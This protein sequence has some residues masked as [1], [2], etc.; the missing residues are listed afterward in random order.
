MGYA[1]LDNYSDGKH[2][3]IDAES[4]VVWTVRKLD[5]ETQKLFNF[6]VRSA[7]FGQPQRHNDVMVTVMIDDVNDN[8]P[9]FEKVRKNDL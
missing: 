9:V 5:A 6:V 4:G 1:I 7:D 2:F 8:P 3:F